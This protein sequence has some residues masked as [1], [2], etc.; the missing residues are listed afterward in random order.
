[1]GS[2][3]RVGEWSLQLTSKFLFH[4]RRAPDGAAAQ[5]HHVRCSIEKSVANTLMRTQS[6][7]QIFLLLQ[8][9]SPLSP[10]HSDLTKWIPDKTTIILHLSDS[11]AGSVRSGSHGWSEEECAVFTRPL[12]RC[13]VQRRAALHSWRGTGVQ[14]CSSFWPRFNGYNLAAD[15]APARAHDGGERDGDREDLWT[16]SYALHGQPWAALHSGPRRHCFTERQKKRKKKK[17]ELGVR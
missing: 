2:E 1:M 7:R 6:S 15:T 12:L 5:V 10:T 16:G 8:A 11:W 13:C 3:C 4:S 14:G 17:M 9:E